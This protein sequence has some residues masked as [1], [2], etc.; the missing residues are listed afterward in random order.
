MLKPLVIVAMLTS[1]ALADPAPPSIRVELQLR[2]GADIRSHVVTITDKSCS[3]IEDKAPDHSDEVKA[4]AHA[5]GANIVLEL[6]W[7]TR[8]ANTEYRSSSSLVVARGGG[9]E[10]GKPGTHLL[11]RVL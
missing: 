9:V 11:V 4:C 1:P 7:S 8:G 5:D 2:V 10:L 3:R 6:D